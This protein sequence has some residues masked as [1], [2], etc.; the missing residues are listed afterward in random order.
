MLD[1][2]LPEDSGGGSGDASALEPV[3]AA[4]GNT[5]QTIP[6]VPVQNT[7]P[8]PQPAAP[9]PPPPGGGP[10]RNETADDSKLYNVFLPKLS[11]PDKKEKAIPL[12]VEL[13]GITNDEANKLASRI[14]IPLVKGVAKDRADEIK[15]R[16]MAVGILP[17]I[18]QQ[19]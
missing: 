11:T 10:Q 8:P 14:V 13:A 1:S 2:L 12:M 15:E 4:S 6:Q 9:T 3:A 16:F 18:R 7:P 19:V 5:Q 17:R